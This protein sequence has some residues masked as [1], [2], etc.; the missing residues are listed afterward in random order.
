[1]HKNTFCAHKKDIIRIIVAL[2]FLSTKNPQK[3]RGRRQGD[4]GAVL[5]NSCIHRSKI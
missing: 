4:G 3:T 2:Y 5:T 1:M